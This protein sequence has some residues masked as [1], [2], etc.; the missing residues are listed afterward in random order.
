MSPQHPPSQVGLRPKQDNKG[1]VLLTVLGQP[2]PWSKDL[3]RELSKGMRLF[4]TSFYGRSSRELSRE[5]KG[6]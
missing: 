4:G 6:K 5:I 2:W 3:H 1:D